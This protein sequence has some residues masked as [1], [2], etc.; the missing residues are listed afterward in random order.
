[1]SAINSGASA[2]EKKNQQQLKKFVSIIHNY[3]QSLNTKVDDLVTHVFF[4]LFRSSI[5]PKRCLILSNC[6]KS[7]CPNP[8][9]N[10]RKLS[11]KPFM[12]E[13]KI[14]KSTIAKSQLAA[15]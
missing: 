9:H 2:I 13:K 3:E 4:L 12:N 5:T 15:L 10:G 6:R 1:M 14:P 7:S 8:R 11:P